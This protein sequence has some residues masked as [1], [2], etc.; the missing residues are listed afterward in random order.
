MIPIESCS[1]GPGVSCPAED[2]YNYAA[3]RLATNEY[4]ANCGVGNSSNVTSLT[5]YWDYQ[6][7]NYNAT[8]LKK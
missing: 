1:S 7:K 3:E 2:F 5:F 8:L 6:D 4:V